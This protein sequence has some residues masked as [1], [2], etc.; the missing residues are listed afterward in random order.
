MWGE[1]RDKLI[2]GFTVVWTFDGNDLRGCVSGKTNENDC[3]VMRATRGHDR[4]RYGGV[5]REIERERN[6]NGCF[7]AKC[8]GGEYRENCVELRVRISSPG[9]FFALK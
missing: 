7:E 2:D 1:K 4:C 9:P 6:V 8:E 5:D 3:V